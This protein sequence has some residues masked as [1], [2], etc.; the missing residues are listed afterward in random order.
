MDPGA[1]YIE[2]LLGKRV[3]ELSANE[4][5][6]PEGEAVRVPAALAGGDARSRVRHDHEAGAG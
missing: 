3:G 5:R 6:F 1:S 4:L 2:H